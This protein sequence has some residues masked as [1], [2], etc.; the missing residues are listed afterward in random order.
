MEIDVKGPIRRE[1]SDADIADLIREAV[2]KKPKSH[3][4]FLD[5]YYQKPV[6]D[7]EMVRIGG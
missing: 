3:Q 1:A 6:D 7:R 2:E 4:D 5:R